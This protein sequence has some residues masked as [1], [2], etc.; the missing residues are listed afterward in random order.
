MY[1]E[2]KDTCADCVFFHVERS[3]HK[4]SEEGLCKPTDD[5]VGSKVRAADG[6][7]AAWELR[8][9]PKEEEKDEGP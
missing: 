7:C 8:D 4:K 2:I 3:R 5:S 1:I 6:A 9:E